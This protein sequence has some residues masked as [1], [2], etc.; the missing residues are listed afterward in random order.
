VE[1]GVSNAGRVTSVTPLRATPPFTDMVVGA[2]RGWQFAPAESTSDGSGGNSSGKRQPVASKVLVAAVVR[3]PTLNTPSLGEPAKDVAAESDETPFPLIATTP[4]FPALA[5][6]P[7][8]VLVEVQVGLDGSVVSASAIRSAP[9]FDDAALAA[10]R[11]WKF[12]PSRVRGRS[13]VARAYVIFGF[14]L[15]ITPLASPK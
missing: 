9:P 8:V 10:V 7:G 2:V 15:P 3:P 11:L 12:R 14:T 1:V 13:V 5:S 4:V 6:Q